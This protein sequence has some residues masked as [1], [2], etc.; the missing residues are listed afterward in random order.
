VPRVG[1]DDLA[2]PQQMLHAVESGGDLD[3]DA[4]ATGLR[5]ESGVT[6]G[7][8]A[9]PHRVVDHPSQADSQP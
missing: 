8:H 9:T 4:G 2:V 6:A 7:H 5:L 1:L 3:P